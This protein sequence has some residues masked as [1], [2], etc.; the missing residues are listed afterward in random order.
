MVY[1]RC[2]GTRFCAN[3]CPV[4]VRRYNFFDYHQKSNP[5]TQKRISNHVFDLFKEPVESIQMQFNPDVTVRMR[6]GNGKM[7]LLCSTN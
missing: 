2:I 6:G 4:K 7:Y 5:Y 3:N 1:N